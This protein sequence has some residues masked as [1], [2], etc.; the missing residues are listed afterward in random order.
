MGQNY[1]TVHARLVADGVGNLHTLLDPHLFVAGSY[2]L[3]RFDDAS[4]DL[5][6]WI[7]YLPEDQQDTILARVVATLLDHGY[8]SFR[9]TYPPPS[10]R[11][12]AA[13]RRRGDGGM[14]NRVQYMVRSIYTCYCPGKLQVQVITLNHQGGA[15]A[16]DVVRHFDLTPLLQYYHGS[17]TACHPSHTP[18]LR[19]NASS[20]VIHN[21]S[22]VEWCRSYTRYLKYVQRGYTVSGD[23]MR[24]LHE[25]VD[26]SLPSKACWV[27]Q[28]HQR[29]RRYV[30]NVEAHIR[31]FNRTSAFL[32]RMFG[33]QC[34]FIVFGF[35]PGGG[36]TVYDV[37]L[38]V[39]FEACPDFVDTRLP[40][41]PVPVEGHRIGTYPSDSLLPDARNV[42][43]YHT[44][45]P[46]DQYIVPYVQE[47][48]SN[49]AAY[50]ASDVI[51]DPVDQGEYTLEVYLSFKDSFV[52]YLEGTPYGVQKPYLQF[53]LDH[54]S[55]RAQNVLDGSHVRLT[56]V[57]FANGLTVQLPSAQVLAWVGSTV[58]NRL[59]RMLPAEGL[60]FDDADPVYRLA[61][62]AVP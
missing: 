23:D 53:C 31:T 61:H 7:P 56:S 9:R 15:R 16:P 52:V 10:D 46:L 34:P 29:A 45:V 3:R 24:Y 30:L 57:T 14:Y 26:A 59:F 55:T 37:R 18:N 60:R 2:L 1:S 58:R 11:G 8:T 50:T 32:Q 41:S 5:D 19:F 49:T 25:R 33:V 43:C 38:L 17:L 20:S 36:R 40:W 4:Q 42:V 51:T 39:R 35:A 21:Q 22:F 54:K 28:W 47:D 48:T 44:L 62:C 13:A 27:V 6:L 12:G